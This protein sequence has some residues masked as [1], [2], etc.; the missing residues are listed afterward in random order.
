MDALTRLNTQL[1]PL[2]ARKATRVAAAEEE[3]LAGV[4]AASAVTLKV[5]FETKEAALA[6]LR[7]TDQ[8]GLSAA[9]SKA[10]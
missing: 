10:L 6:T 3:R 9:A 1:A 5:T 8:A 2:E 7:A 4:A